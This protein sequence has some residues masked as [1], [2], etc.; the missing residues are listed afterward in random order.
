MSEIENYNETL[1]REEFVASCLKL[2]KFISVGEKNHLV[3]F[4]PCIPEQAC[5]SHQPQISAVSRA[6]LEEDELYQLPVEDRL[7]ARGKH[8]DL[9]LKQKQNL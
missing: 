8:K 5:F 9:R 6:I 1:N 7:L 2:I 4:K 3:N